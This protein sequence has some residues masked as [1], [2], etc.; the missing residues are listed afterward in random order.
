MLI[1]VLFL[2]FQMLPIFIQNLLEELM[3]K[4]WGTIQGHDQ[5]ESDTTHHHEL[6]LHQGRQCIVSTISFKQTTQ[7]LI[8][9]PSQLLDLDI[10]NISLTW[11]K[12]RKNNKE[13]RMTGLLFVIQLRSHKLWANNWMMNHEWRV[14]WAIEARQFCL[15]QHTFFSVPSIL[16]AHHSDLGIFLI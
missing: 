15:F 9:L 3:I 4:G 5:I 16:S 14:R 7:Q 8:S 2:L 13:R 11:V 10:S 6:F 12:K 1:L